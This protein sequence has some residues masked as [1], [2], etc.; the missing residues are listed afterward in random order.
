M[1]LIDMIR[2]AS[3][4]YGLPEALIVGVMYVESRFKPRALEGWSHGLDAVDA[5]YR[6]WS[7]GDDPYDPY[8]SMREGRDIFVR[9]RTVL[10]VT[11]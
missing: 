9:W 1:P 6:S 3:K 11:M 8:Q 5:Q 4:K 7:W 10:T 2:A